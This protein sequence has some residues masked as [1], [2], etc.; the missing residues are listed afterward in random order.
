[1]SLP[2]LALRVLRREVG[3]RIGAGREDAGTRVDRLASLVEA[4][5]GA[6]A[7]LEE[8]VAA[9]RHQDP[10]GPTLARPP[11]ARAAR[12]DRLHAAREAVGA[13][14][15]AGE[16]VPDGPDRVCL[17]GYGASTWRAIAVLRR[18]AGGGG[19]G[20]W[21]AAVVALPA[22]ELG[23]AAPGFL[24]GLRAEPPLRRPAAALHA[25][26][27]LRQDH[28]HALINAEGAIGVALEA[29]HADS[30]EALRAECAELAA[31]M[32]ALDRGIAA[33][34]REGARAAGAA[35]RP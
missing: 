29:G 16:L 3:A 14:V 21:A 13:L 17:P 32:R 33:A 35:H 10:L 25:L 12:G 31:R 2:A 8:A 1:V 7:A 20:A 19:E 23:D 18:G 15:V 5:A 9:Q 28:R 22:A 11:S 27:A 26:E 6:E 24:R 4:D 30:A 34:W